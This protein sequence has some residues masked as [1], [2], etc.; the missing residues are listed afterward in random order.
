MHNFINHVHNTVYWK[1]CSLRNVLCCWIPACCQHLK[2]I[3]ILIPKY[4]SIGYNNGIEEYQIISRMFEKNVKG[5]ITNV[6]I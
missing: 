3:G 2:L 6:F 5:K 1:S 4:V